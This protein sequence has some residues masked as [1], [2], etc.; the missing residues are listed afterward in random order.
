MQTFSKYFNPCY[1]TARL[2]PTFITK[3]ST[4]VQ[5]ILMAA[6]L[7]APVFS[8][9]DSIYLQILWCFT[10]LTTAAS[11]YRYY[12]YGWQTVQVLKGR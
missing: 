8:Y 12:H 7:A 6:F 9:A 1:T 10:S 5:L 11:A 4:E 3:V 2:K